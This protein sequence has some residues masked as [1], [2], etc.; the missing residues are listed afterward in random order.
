V[1]PVVRDVCLV[2]SQNKLFQRRSRYS[3]LFMRLFHDVNLCLRDGPSRRPHTDAHNR[4]FSCS[5][6]LAPNLVHPALAHSCLFSCLVAAHSVVLFLK[7]PQDSALVQL[8]TKRTILILRKYLWDN[9][10]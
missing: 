9:T 3:V 5:L 8:H 6:I 1:N 10:A 7:N 2:V 4:N